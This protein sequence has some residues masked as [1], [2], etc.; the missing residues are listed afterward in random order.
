LARSG[1]FLGVVLQ[2]G[3]EREHDFAARVTEACRERRALAEVALELQKLNVR[4]V[5][6]QG[7]RFP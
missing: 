2:I 1:G 5:F 7:S 6:E 4:V 3:V